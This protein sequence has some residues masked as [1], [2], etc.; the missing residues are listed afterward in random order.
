[1]ALIF[2]LETSVDPGEGSGGTGGSVTDLFFP[3]S[4]QSMD[5]R[6]HGY[7]DMI[8]MSYQGG[9]SWSSSSSFTG[10]SGDSDSLSFPE[11]VKSGTSHFISESIFWIQDNLTSLALSSSAPS[12]LAS[13][14]VSSSALTRATGESGDMEVYREFLEG[15]RFWVQKV[16]VPILMVIGVIGNSITIAIMTRRRMRSSTNNYLAALA[17]ID[18]MYLI[19]TF[20]LS[21]RHYSVS[22]QS[23]YYLYW[24]LRPYFLMLADCCSNSSVWLTVTFTI[25][26]FIVVSHPIRG[27]VW[28]TESRARKVILTVFLICF[29]WTLPTPFEYVIRESVD[30][31][32]NATSYGLAASDLGSNATYKSVYYWMTSSLF[33]FVPLF[34]LAIFNSFLIRS[35]HVSRKQR[36]DMTQCPST[37][38]PPIKTNGTRTGSKVRSVVNTSGVTSKLESSSASTSS[39]SQETK[40]TIMLIAVVILFLFC[41]LPTAVMLIFSSVHEFE[42]GTRGDYLSR[43]FGNIFN[44]LVAINSAGNFLLYCFFSQRYRKTFISIFCPCYKRQLRYFQSGGTTATATYS[45]TTTTKKIN[46]TAAAVAGAPAIHRH[47]RLDRGSNSSCN[48]GHEEK[49]MQGMSGSSSP[50][51]RRVDDHRPDETTPFLKPGT[52][53]CTRSPSITHHDPVNMS[54]PKEIPDSIVVVARDPS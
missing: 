44:F 8:Q 11:E 52:S 9:D 41:Q 30:P 17:I 45:V 40:I 43:G 53:P 3:P 18:M 49:E 25:E 2:S 16:L 28:C 19:F 36:S 37:P 38:N 32:T 14:S 27:K 48:T 29:A 5:Q 42:E 33:I 46:R 31:E 15:T 7:S 23:D 21:F 24:Q 6:V 10:G 54:D 13:S 35:V 50:N 47:D 22:S 26:R 12:A 34:L 1:M 20:I 39:S 51:G 4:N